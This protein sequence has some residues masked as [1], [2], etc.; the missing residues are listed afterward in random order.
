M[1]IAQYVPVNRYTVHSNLTHTDA[2]MEVD[3][4]CTRA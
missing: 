3:S 2:K 1:H 4:Y